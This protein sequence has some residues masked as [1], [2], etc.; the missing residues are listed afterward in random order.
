MDM[1]FVFGIF[2]T[3]YGLIGLFGFQFAIPKK[4]RGQSWTKKYIRL[5]GL[6]WIVL[7]V[8]WIILASFATAYEI[9]LYTKIIALLIL[10]TPA[11]L[12][13]LIAGR[14]YRALLDNT[15]P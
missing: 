1:I 13:S 7:G 6:S 4:F 2:W 10:S 9:E 14:K 5:Q 3:I 15:K 12:Y 11:L 8:P